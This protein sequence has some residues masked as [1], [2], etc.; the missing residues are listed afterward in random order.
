MSRTTVREYVLNNTARH[1]ANCLF[2]ER[3]VPN[4]GLLETA[5]IACPSSVM[6][7]TRVREK[8]RQLPVLRALCNEQ[9]REKQRQLPVLQFLELPW[10]DQR[11]VQSNEGISG[12]LPL[13]PH[14][15]TKSARVHRLSTKRDLVKNSKIDLPGSDWV[16]VNEL[17]RDTQ[18]IISASFTPSCNCK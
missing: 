14:S 15:E 1:S 7:W 18:I 12:L 10:P 5:P 16:H 2:F 3:Y 6:S 13:T 8:Q 11:W 9:H 4:K 17:Q